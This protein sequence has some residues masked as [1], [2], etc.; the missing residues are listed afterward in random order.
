MVGERDAMKSFGDIR[1]GRGFRCYLVAELGYNWCV[2]RE[3][4]RNLEELR[5]LIR[6]AAE[7]GF[8]C[9]K[10]QLRSLD[11]GGYY[12]T[13]G[14]SLDAAIPDPRSPWTRRG[15]YVEAREPDEEVLAFVS[16]A[17]AEHGIG[18]TASAWDVPS[19][20]L[21]ARR[22]V[23]WLKLASAS[24]SDEEVT[25]AYAR[26]GL[27]IVASTGMHS[28]DEVDAAVKILRQHGSDVLLAHTTSAYP[29]PDD[30]VNLAVMDTLAAR[31][32]GPVGYSGHELGI[33]LSLAAVVRG[34]VW[35]ER[36]FTRDRT[37]WHKD[38]AASLEADGL[39]RLARD[40]RRYERAVGDGERRVRACEYPYRVA[41]RRL[42]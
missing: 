37:Q 2:S 27:P 23:P 8:D 15:D 9:V 5:W 36:H 22:D 24:L 11:A 28:L 34:A 40:V 30:D 6:T 3:H 10:L 29:C 32:G 19:L 21:L 4:A 41:L 33:A 18:W 17:C 42:G 25:R 38:H 39:R 16:S 35:L 14:D 1:I 12:A 13:R 20:T 26:T 31:Y 7:A